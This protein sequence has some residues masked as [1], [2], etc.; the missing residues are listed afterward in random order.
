MGPAA[1]GS[2]PAS[3][4]KPEDPPV[5]GDDK[6]QFRRDVATWV[7]YLKSAAE[8]KDK[9]AAARLKTLVTTLGSSLPLSFRQMVERDVD[10]GL[11][12]DSNASFESQE[13]D[14]T[15]GLPCRVGFAD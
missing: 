10:Q 9:V 15:Y 6:Y 11:I 13:K 5:L 8:A 3:S 4:R 1:K 14:S 7:N 12:D 2:A